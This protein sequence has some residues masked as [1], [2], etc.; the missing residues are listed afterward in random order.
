MIRLLLRLYPA[1]WRAE[2]GEELAQIVA[3]KSL[4]A[5]VLFNVLWSGLRERLRQSDPGIFFGLL[6]YCF[7]FTGN[8][9]MIVLPRFATFGFLSFGYVEL[10]VLILAASYSVLRSKSA[11][12]A[13]LTAGGL[14]AIANFLWCVAWRFHV[15]NP[16]QLCDPKATSV[17]G[18]GI[19]TLFVQSSI[20]IANEE[21][22]VLVGTLIVT[23]AVIALPG[24]FLGWGIGRGVQ[25]YRRAAG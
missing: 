23:T 20:N 13:T 5:G 11:F 7:A 3:S 14:S 17:P 6:L 1:A 25:G 4:T 2:Y 19:T 10:V 12:R 24:T 15:L 21:F 16:P 9:M 8:L 22:V 18:C